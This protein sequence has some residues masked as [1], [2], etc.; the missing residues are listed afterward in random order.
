MSH[1][2]FAVVG[3]TLLIAEIAA[4]SGSLF[5]A[6]LTDNLSIVGLEDQQMETLA[7]TDFDDCVVGFECLNRKLQDLLA[8]VSKGGALIYLETEYSGGSGSQAAA[9]LCG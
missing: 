1:C 9:F 6:K 8:E 3:D 5:V 2:I 4:Q 7:G